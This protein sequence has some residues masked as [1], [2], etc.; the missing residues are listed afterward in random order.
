MNL[1]PVIGTGSLSV[2]HFHLLKYIWNALSH[3]H[4]HKSL[5]NVHIK[6]HN[7]KEHPSSQNY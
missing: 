4:R 3:K 7:N 2:C 1:G 5:T 6:L